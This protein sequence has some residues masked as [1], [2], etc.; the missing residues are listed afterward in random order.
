VK[1]YTVYAKRWGNGCEL[2]VNGVGVTQSRGLD[3]AEAM[4]R[5]Y[6]ATTTGVPAGSFAVA[7]VAGEPGPDLTAA[8]LAALAAWTASDGGDE[9]MLAAVRAAL[10]YQRER[11]AAH[12]ARPHVRVDPAQRFGQPAVKGISCEAIGGMLLA[13]E[14]VATVADDYDLTRADV[15]VAAWYQGMYGTRQYRRAWKGWAEQA[16]QA[17]WDT[18]TVDY[19]QIPDPPE[20]VPLAEAF[21]A[22]TGNE[23]PAPMDDERRREYEAKVE[24]A[25]DDAR[26]IY[27]DPG[28]ETSTST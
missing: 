4:A 6:V 22:A 5:S 15:L 28:T 19:G 24:R 10:A 23:P 1:T 8:E 9:G 25:Q 16:G 21:R 7:V 26:R 3:D 17:M 20:R 2:H 18:R 11:N 14:D 27:G 13:G 12:D